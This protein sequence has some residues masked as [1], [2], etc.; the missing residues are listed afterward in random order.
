V[1]NEL[2]KFIFWIRIWIF[3]PENLGAVS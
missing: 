3:F 2:K 1:L